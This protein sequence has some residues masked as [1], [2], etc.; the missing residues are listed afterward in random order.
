MKLKKIK[1][2]NWHIFKNDT[3]E[4]DGNTLITG[5]NS[6]G[7]STLMDAIYYVL[8][9]GDQN[10]FNKAANEGSKRTL[11]TYI[12]GKLGIEKR[13]FLRP[14]ENVIGY[15]V[16]EF[17]DLENLHSQ[18]VGVSIEI[19][20]TKPKSHF[21]VIDSYKIKDEDYIQNNR[22]LNFKEFKSNLKNKK[23][24]IDD[25]PDSQKERRKKLGRDIF[26]LDD[27]KRFFDLLQNA[28]SFK[29]ISEV[30]SFVNSFLLEE[31]NINLD[32]LRGEIRS[33]QD[34][35]KMLIKEKEKINLLSKFIPEAEKFIENLETIKYLDVLKIDYEIKKSKVN[36][37]DK[38]IEQQRLVDEYKKLTGE[39]NS[40][41]ET[42]ERLKRELQ[43]LENKDEYKALKEKENLLENYRKNLQLNNDK[44]REF[45]NLINDEQNINDCLD[46]NYKFNDFVKEKDFSRLKINLQN[47]SNEIIQLRNTYLNK[48]AELNFQRDNN[49]KII[50][51]K[52]KEL[53]KL[54]K[55]IHNYPQDVI[56]LIEITKNAIKSSNPKETNPEV[57]PLCEYIEIL[58]EKWANAL[59]GYLNTQRFNLIIDPKYYDIATIAYNN[60]KNNCSV[61]TSGI[62][63]VK[64]IQLFEPKENSLMNKIEIKNK[65]AKLYA[66]YLL[67][68]LICVDNVLDLKKY[69]S[70]I[71]PEVM[72]YKN[73]VIKACNPEIY[74]VPYIGK[75]SR[76]KRIDIL[77]NEIFDLKKLN[78]GYDK[79]IFTIQKCIGIINETKINKLLE[80]ENHW[81]VIAQL[82]E[83]INELNIEISYTKKSTGMFKITDSINYNKRK[84]GENDLKL[85]D[86]IEK[87]NNNISNRGIAKSKIEFITREIEKNSYEF[88]EKFKLLEKENYDKYLNKYLSNNKLNGSKIIFDL[89]NANKQN[90]SLEYSLLKGMQDYS[91][92]YKA[93]M[94][95]DISHLKDY[96]NEYYDLK[97][98]GII[99][100]EFAAKEAYQRAEFSF[101]EDFISKLKEKIEN[102]Q[103]M[104]DKINKNLNMH[105]FGNDNER[106]KFHY[107]PTKDNEFF[108]YYKIIMSGKLMNVKDLFTE[109]LDEKDSEIMKELFDNISM[110]TN[111]S[112]AEIK[113]QR[114]LDYRNYMNY[115]IKITNKYGDESYFSKINKEKSGGETQTPFYIVMASCFDELMN[116]DLNKVK[117]TCIVVFDE[118]FNNMDE[119]RIKSLMEF[120]KQL[121]IQILIIVPSNRI[122]SIMPYMD[123]TIGMVKHNH[124]AK[125]RIVGKDNE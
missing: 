98:R 69:K 72:I 23:I 4:I 16:L 65:Y 91:Y 85:N 36:L 53:D 71:N 6:S 44:L 29:P 86:I 121:N 124:S 42:I 7:K 15:I 37:E 35:H 96:I 60:H 113:L 10:H 122:S 67:A 62:V 52:E 9:G 13:P 14:E 56:N 8:S 48:L 84:I 83:N 39:E 116:K 17:F 97:N 115:D 40:L 74:R 89:D 123:T 45:L 28:I 63:N 47:Y 50:K 22:P 49:N 93:S 64:E 125:I 119:S 59:E 46:L 24:E 94:N 11:E 5:E 112:D 105:P 100:Y 18:I 70:S 81:Q 79:D 33:Y 109:I 114:Y 78:D 58:D 101:R 43:D 27:Y 87:R 103:K 41:R 31:D 80:Y 75:N 12:R 55:G 92:K 90:S 34:I 95:P 51:D 99:E 118:A 111:S 19:F 73:Y 76:E 110:E 25:L 68:N 102:S 1:L 107:E 66:N 38:K 20:S 26:K 21:F 32:S 120:Y 54:N 82:E 108:N 77:K 104:L 117:S 61:Y 106:Y 57:R 88:N 3:I 2:I 30:S